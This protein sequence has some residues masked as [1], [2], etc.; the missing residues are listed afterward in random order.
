MIGISLIHGYVCPKLCNIA[1]YQVTAFSSKSALEASVSSVHK[2][3]FIDAFRILVKPF[4]LP[5]I[6]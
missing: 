1:N 2:L 5:Q 3:I 4:F 6:P